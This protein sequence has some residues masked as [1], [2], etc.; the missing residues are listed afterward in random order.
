MLANGFHPVGIN[1][2]PGYDI[3]IFVAGETLDD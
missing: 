1:R 3:S 2:S